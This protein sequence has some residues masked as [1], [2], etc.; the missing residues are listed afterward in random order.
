MRDPIHRTAWIKHAEPR[1]LL[2]C[3]GSP[4][5]CMQSVLSPNRRKDGQ[6]LKLQIGGSPGS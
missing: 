1:C 2:A 6:A 3:A 4:Q 5:L